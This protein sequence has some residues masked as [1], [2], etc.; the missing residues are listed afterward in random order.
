MPSRYQIDMTK[1][2]QKDDIFMNRPYNRHTMFT[3]LVEA[4]GSVV[5]AEV[6]SAGLRLEITAPF[7]AE[8]SLGESVAVEGVCLTVVAIG[9]GS[10]EVEVIPETISRSRFSDFLSGALVNLERALKVGDRLGGHFVSGHVDGLGRVLRVDSGFDGHRVRVEFPSN[11]HLFFP[12]K[13]SVTLDGVSLTIVSCDAVAFEVALI[14]HTL[15]STTLSRLIVGD[16]LHLEVDLLAR[17]LFNA[18]S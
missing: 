13:G 10:F 8:L 2:F 9:D 18:S 5:R 1:R 16:L 3:G 7:A 17:Y 4:V 14:P 12:E 15:K 6:S 11:L